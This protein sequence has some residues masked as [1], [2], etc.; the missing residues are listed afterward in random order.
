MTQYVTCLTGSAVVHLNRAV[1]VAA[2]YDLAIER[3]AND[4]ERRHLV[5]AR[6]ALGG[7]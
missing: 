1:A 4:A 7:T 6:S 2:A 3:C 5:A